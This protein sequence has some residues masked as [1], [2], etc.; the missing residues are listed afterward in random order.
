MI[1]LG[2]A[3]NMTLQKIE[4]KNKIRTFPSPSI[5]A[6]TTVYRRASRLKNRVNRK[7]LKKHWTTL[8]PGIR[9]WYTKPPFV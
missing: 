4:T 5:E 7:K 1:S 9:R 6:F 2:N 8:I 3:A